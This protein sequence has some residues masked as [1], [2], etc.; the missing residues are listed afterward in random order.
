M[1][2]KLLR[3][4]FPFRK[5]FYISELV[6]IFFK[7]EPLVFIEE[8]K[9]RSIKTRKILGVR[10]ILITIENSSELTG[11]LVREL[12]KYLENTLNEE[13]YVETNIIF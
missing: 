10:E 11:G 1:I 4:I 8:L 6:I 3:I 5:N 13:I 2:T 7:H 9:L 12:E